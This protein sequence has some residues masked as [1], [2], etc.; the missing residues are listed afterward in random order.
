MDAEIKSK[1]GWFNSDQNFIIKEEI[2]AKYKSLK[3]LEWN[4]H[5]DNDY[6]RRDSRIKIGECDS[7]EG[8]LAD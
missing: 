1:I 3:A 5:K 2:E 6:K 8:D 4:N 7:D